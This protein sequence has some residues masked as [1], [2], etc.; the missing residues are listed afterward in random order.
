MRWLALLA[1]L[2][3]A[4]LAAQVPAEVTGHV[5]ARAD[6][7]PI[8]NAN[9]EDAVTDADGTFTL[10]GLE[11][12]RRTLRV[13]ALGFRATSVEVDVANG[14]MTVVDIALDDAPATLQRVAVVAAGDTAGATTITRTEI[15][16]SGRSDL[17]A[18][19]QDRAGVLVVSTGGPGAPSHL[20]IRGS[21]ANEILV[22]VDGVPIN[23]PITGE[24]DL[25]TIPLSQI[26]RVTVLPGAQSAR[27]GGRAMAGV[28]LIET[29]R[30]SIPDAEVDGSA[31]SYDER[32]GAVSV[33][34]PGPGDV[35]GVLSA[36]RR[37]SRGD[38][39]YDVPLVRG[40]GTAIRGDDG[41]SASA[42][43]GAL[44]HDAGPVDLRLHA[45]YDANARGL[46]GSVAAP[47]FTAHGEDDRLA[48]GLDATE[49]RGPIRWTADLEADRE[50]TRFTDS[51]PPIGAAYDDK[52]T[53]NSVT[54]LASA[55]L[56]GLAVG[57]E[58]RLIGVMANDLATSAPTTQHEDGLWARATAS[59]T[60]A[61]VA[62]FGAE[63]GARVDWSSLLSGAF[64]SPKVGVTATR[65]AL[66][67]AVDYGDAFTPPSLAD[68]FFHEGVLVQ[69][70]PSLQPE[71]VHGDLEG[72]LTL[73]D[74]P[75]GPLRFGG[76]I[77]AYQSNVDGMII[78]FPDYRFVWSPQNTNVHRSGWDATATA[79]LLGLSV[80]GTITDVAVD[81]AGGAVTGQVV[82]R[83]RVTG[84][85]TTA[86]TRWRVTL[87]VTNQY[88]GDRRTVQGSALNSLGAYWLTDAQLTVHVLGE[89]DV[90]GGVDNAFD[91][92]V[93][94]LFDYPLP[95]RTYRVG[96]R[97]HTLSVSGLR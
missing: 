5:T 29:R 76:E 26:E 14:R 86:I 93:A 8:A 41:F 58:S 10:R 31:A 73:R 39:P 38:F 46:P 28:V 75:V 85:V 79:S 59:H 83:P 96:F 77:A 72:R 54:G 71:R 55:A 56:G 44:T 32:D 30:P 67:A 1:L 13:R 74:V 36:S 2:A 33:G 81:Y 37:L 16:Q 45:T 88:V 3:A 21:S 40:G 9:V 68:Q 35:D 52:V 23:S 53:A 61:H 70:N 22:L 65:G 11:P 87:D 97:L 25:S 94:L 91:H 19:L 60:I 84:A 69:P 90:L 89:L 4:P 15:E 64:V 63:A 20:S 17:G 62:T 92:H 50:Q 66:T 7:R 95:A 24:A 12:G 27:W 49:S 42:V 47:S 82:Y 80:R 6:G 57:A 51:T 18:L 48:G 43:D 34:G 78:W